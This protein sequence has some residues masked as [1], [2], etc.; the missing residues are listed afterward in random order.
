MEQNVWWR[1]VCTRSKRFVAPRAK[2][3]LELYRKAGDVREA[4]IILESVQNL[5]EFQVV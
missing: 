4:L 2:R 3:F 1:Y 5:R